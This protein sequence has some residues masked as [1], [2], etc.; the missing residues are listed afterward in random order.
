MYTAAYSWHKIQV[1]NSGDAHAKQVF[2]CFLMENN[3]VVQFPAFLI[4]SHA[5]KKSPETFIP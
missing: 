5:A 1:G 4:P 3:V 2:S